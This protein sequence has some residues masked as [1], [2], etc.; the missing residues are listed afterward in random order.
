M[1]LPVPRTDDRGGAPDRAPPAVESV[2][3]ALRV[4]RC[5]RLEEP[6]LGVTDIA[7]ELGLPKSTVHRLLATLEAEGFVHQL[8]G[9][10]YVL[11]WKA[12][13][14]GAAVWAWNAMRQ[15]VL[16]RLE[17]LVTITGET[18]H[19]GVLD[20][21][22]VLYIEKVESPRPLRMPSAVG[23]RVPVHCTALGKT[24]LAGVESELAGRLIRDRPLRSF[25][26]NTIT[27][28]DTLLREIEQARSQGFAIDR[29]EIEE[30][31]MCVAAPVV[32]EQGDTSAAI[33]ISGPASRITPRLEDQI[34]A[35]RETCAALSRDLGPNARRLRE[36]S[37]LVPPGT[38]SE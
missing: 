10:R 19:L 8:N 4:L 34:V 32:D 21:G 1:L 13:E 28:P 22:E 2:R 36:I 27:E 26:T 18:G 11:G 31:L 33:S 24:L 16:R 37:T 6:E 38:S 30:G 20:E 5:F 9:S 12:F 3:R 17:S 35:V 15:P 25:T 14:L 7:R 23:R 29:E